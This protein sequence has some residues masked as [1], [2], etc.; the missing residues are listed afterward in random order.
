MCEAL[1][2]ENLSEQARAR[3]GVVGL[4]DFGDV[5]GRDDRCGLSSQ[6]LLQSATDDA[7]QQSVRHRQYRPADTHHGCHRLYLRH[8]RC[9]CPGYLSED[10][11]HLAANSIKN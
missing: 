1:R 4:S 3:R 6:A 2:Q 7:R 8:D 10:Q 9:L 11:W 5:D